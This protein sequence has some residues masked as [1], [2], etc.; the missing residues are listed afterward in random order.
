MLIQVDRALDFEH[1]AI[2]EAA[3]YGLKA[4]LKAQFPSGGFPQVWT[5]PVDSKPVRKAR[6]PDFDWKTEGKVR[7]YWD[8]YTLNDN[9]AGTVADTLIMAHEVYK[10][11][12]Y[13]VALQKL[14]DFLIL[15]QM[16]DPQPGWCQ[17]YNDD[18]MPM[19]A[20]KFEP[21]AITGWESQ[22]VMEALIKIA[23]Y[24]GKKE[25]LE[26]IQR[27]LTYFQKSVLADG[28]IARY[29]ELKTNKPLFM[30]ARYQLTYDE[31]AAPKHYGWKQPARFKEIEKKYELAKAGVT[32]ERAPTAQ[33]L[34]ES[35]GRILR[36]LDAEGRWL[37][38]YAGEGLVGQPKF[39]HGFRYISSEVFSRNV[40]LLSAY[41]AATR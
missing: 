22:D 27:A 17:Q 30:D 13:K 11:A 6:Y 23:Q 35:I 7:N 4:L 1:A 28:K 40:E 21:P 14:G 5:G 2:H 32:R 34:E 15:A 36:E 20:R 16:P 37:S 33:Q 25:Y 24:T 10:E 18:M 12:A 39:E 3:L 41:L 26:P 31:S 29:Y 8:Y 19:W 38:T 9:V